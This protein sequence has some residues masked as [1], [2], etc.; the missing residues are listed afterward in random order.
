[1]YKSIFVMLL[2]GIAPVCVQGQLF[3]TVGGEDTNEATLLAGEKYTI[4]IVSESKEPIAYDVSIAF[5]SDKPLGSLKLI[6]VTQAAGKDAGYLPLESVTGYQC[7]VGKENAIGEHFLFDYAPDELGKTVLQMIDSNT[8]EVIDEVQLTVESPVE[9][10]PV[11]SAFTYQGRLHDSGDAAEGSF[12]MLFGLHADATSQFGLI[13]TEVAKNNVDVVGGY[14]TVRLD[15]GSSAEILNGDRRWLEVAVRPGGSAIEYTT[16]SPRYEVTCA[17]YASHSL[18]AA[19]SDIANVA[20]SADDAAM[21]N[22]QNA[23]SFATASHSH[24]AHDHDSTYVNKTGDSISGSSATSLLT[25][26]NSGTGKAINGTATGIGGRG[27]YGNA[28]ATGNFA[29]YGGYFSASGDAGR[30]VSG[31]ASGSEGRGVYGRAQSNGE[32][33]NYGG[34]FQADG[35]TGQAV[36]GYAANAGNYMNYGGY[37]RSAGRYGHGVHGKAAGWG[38]AGVYGEA[39][40]ESGANTNYG[41]YF[42]A[43]GGDGYGV[44]SE[45]SGYSGIAVLGDA[46]ATGNYA[47]TGGHFNSN[48]DQGIGVMGYA[49]SGSPLVHYGGKFK[50]AGANGR[51]VYGWATSGAGHGV[52]GRADGA[53]GI[54]VYADAFISNGNGTGVYATGNQHDFY[55]ASGKYSSGSSI[56]W[57]SNVRTIDGA[58]D[59]VGRLR[60]VYFKWDAEH[61]G[62]EDMGMI[63]EE[64]GQVVPEIVSYEENG[65]DATGMDYSKMSALL[66]EAVKELKAEND[67]LRKR[68]EALESR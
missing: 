63:A 28:S 44:Y 42:T 20:L 29:N 60:G 14:F 8:Q 19:Q 46:S 66:I 22:G 26:V 38:G 10:E 16:L 21:L 34:Y 36:Y 15:F 64:V 3:L 35:A 30:G 2:I 37:F 43:A 4:A 62:S 32:S 6:E 11:T 17:P 48:G 23:A 53:D 67:R 39:T 24:T 40:T 7:W 59:K 13:G 31:Y 9:P 12:D 55:A 5:S 41:G 68:I 52:H 47:N 27:V 25:V 50:A 45:A 61:G 33:T 58:L 18:H 54:A 51:G 65:V 1:M 57:K 56:R 49:G